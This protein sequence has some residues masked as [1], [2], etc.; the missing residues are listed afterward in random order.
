MFKHVVECFR[1]YFVRKHFS[2][3]RDCKGMLWSSFFG[4]LQKRSETVHF[5]SFG[6][7]HVP[8]EIKDFVGN[9]SIIANIV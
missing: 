7:E 2:R 9:K 6:V 1:S 3:K 5:D 4:L 8:E